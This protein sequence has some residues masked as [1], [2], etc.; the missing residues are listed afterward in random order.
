MF[1]LKSKQ[2]VFLMCFA[3]CWPSS[4]RLPVLLRVQRTNLQ[5]MWCF[6]TAQ[7][8]REAGQG[9]SEPSQTSFFLSACILSSSVRRMACSSGG[10]LSTLSSDAAMFVQ[11]QEWKSH[12]LTSLVLRVTIGAKMAYFDFHFL[13]FSLT[14]TRKMREEKYEEKK[15]ER[16]GAGRKI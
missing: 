8:K 15:R 9:S 3:I 5:A 10:H 14:D 6:G 16:Q 4:L 7:W 13:S 2:V 1:V 11:K 12:I